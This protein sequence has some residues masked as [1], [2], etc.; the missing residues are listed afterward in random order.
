MC[1]TCASLAT[2]LL[3]HIPHILELVQK[4]LADSERS[5]GVLKL[6]LGLIGDLA[7]TFP[8]GQIK[9]VL[10]AE[11]IMGELRSKGR[12]SAEIKRTLR[13]AR[14]VSRSDVSLPNSPDWLL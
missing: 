13:W 11:W 10:L 6:S 12:Y 9:Q 14:E 3:P 5:D 8:D 4:C 1:L 2:L 7:D